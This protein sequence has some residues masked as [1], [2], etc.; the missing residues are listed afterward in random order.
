[1]KKKYTF[2]EEINKEL[3]KL[4]QHLRGAKYGD[5]TI[6]QYKN[7][8]G[9]YLEWLK[10]NN[11]QAEE[12][13]YKDIISFI[14]DLQKEYSQNHTKRIIIAIK[15]YHDSIGSTIN[16]VSGIY[17][18]GTRKA[19]INDIISYEEIKRCYEEY[20]AYN[21]R[22]KRNK[23]VLSLMLHQ[24]ITTTDIHQL[25]VRHIRLKEG[26]IYIPQSDYTNSRILQL[27]ALQMLEL[28]EY[29]QII[30]PRILA[31]IHEPKQGKKVE[32]IKEGIEEKL[33]VGDNGGSNMKSPLMNL[34][35]KL[36]KKHPS[37]GSCKIIRSTVIAEWLK[38]NDV[39]KVQYM[40]GHK[41]V[42]ST[43]RYNVMNLVELKDSLNKYHP[44]K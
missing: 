10:G 15:H 13:I 38:T 35:K 43:E 22:Q 29:V 12:I 4:E 33:F 42:S 26:K 41:Y 32:N 18:K 3:E 11:Y 25:E 20:E 19:I 17:I 16:P 30:R 28:Q 37:I 44:M 14:E 9:I 39:R 23:I 7:C 1:M 36:K 24:A 8:T 21:D 2:T 34:F 27:E 40:A 5:H 31:Q 6:N